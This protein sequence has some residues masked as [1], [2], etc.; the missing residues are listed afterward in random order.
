VYHYIKKK[1]ALEVNWFI[2]LHLLYSQCFPVLFLQDFLNEMSQTDE[3]VNFL[4]NM[5]FPKDEA[6]MAITRCGMLFVNFVRLRFF[7]KISIFSHQ[8]PCF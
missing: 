4:V 1:S 6:T 3:K 5:G 8:K 7:S 2:Q